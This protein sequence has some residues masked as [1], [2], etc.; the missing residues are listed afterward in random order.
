MVVARMMKYLNKSDCLKLEIEE[1]ELLM[2]QED[3]EVNVR[4]ILTRVNRR[5][6]R[7]FEIFSTKE[8]SEQFVASKV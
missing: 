5:G 6:S 1:L 7:I 2:G 8:K 3:S 4:K